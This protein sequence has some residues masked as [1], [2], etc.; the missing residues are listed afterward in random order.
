[1]EP[2]PSHPPS[3][4][5]LEKNP[6]KRSLSNPID[7]A[8]P[9]IKQLKT[10]QTTTPN[11]PFL[12]TPI[13]TPTPEET[14]THSE[15]PPT[16]LA[17]ALPNDEDSHMGDPNAGG[18]SDETST[19]SAKESAQNRAQTHTGPIDPF[20]TPTPGHQPRARGQHKPNSARS[21]AARTISAR[22]PIGHPLHPDTQASRA[23]NNTPQL[24][25]GQ[26]TL[27]TPL[28]HPGPPT[29]P[30]LI[31]Q[32]GYMPNP[33]LLSHPLPTSE[34]GIITLG[35]FRYTEYP[36]ESSRLYPQLGHNNLLHHQPQQILSWT[37]K[38]G[39][40]VLVRE[41]RARYEID[42]EARRKCR[43]DIEETITNFLGQDA[44]FEL[45]DPKVN[46]LATRGRTDPP[47]HTL[48]YNLHDAHLVKL[49]AHPIIAT[50]KC[51][52]IISPFHQ[53]IP[54]FIT[55]ITG[56]TCKSNTPSGQR[57]ALEAVRR[58]LMSNTS[59]S[60]D[61]DQIAG[62]EAFQKLIDGLQVYFVN[63]SST[64]PNEG[65]WNVE[66]TGMP[67][68]ITIEQHQAL[69]DRI[70]K[71]TFPTDDHGDGIALLRSRECINCKCISHTVSLCPLYDM[72]GWLGPSKTDLQSFTKNPSTTE[73]SS[74]GRPSR[75]RGAWM[76]GGTGNRGSNR[77]LSRGFMNKRG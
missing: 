56:L 69:M 52:L 51:V 2:E 45:S 28:E 11:L 31:L 50:P 13:M 58:G 48:V 74:R 62:A 16:S 7:Y 70:K 39:N 60:N 66:S 21:A 6:R 37:S 15:P 72:K 40:K 9:G 55:S 67:R 19:V 38:R 73:Q 57:I 12:P 64:H 26:P 22:H 63:T 1:M 8:L 36:R 32:P 68:S 59:L 10:A 17:Q 29:H 49:L 18:G 42:V 47:W 44:S 53:V 34:D 77:S 76:R 20:T 3:P 14:P 35:D 61:F 5:S 25:P 65:W 33:T 4:E 46:P 30:G 43:D 71:L 23:P 41:F 54:T 75:G 27:P 24:G